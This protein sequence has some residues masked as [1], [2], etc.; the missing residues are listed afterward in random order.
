M[1]GDSAASSP[2]RLEAPSLTWSMDFDMDHFSARLQDWAP[3]LVHDM[4]KECLAIA[5]AFGITDVQVT[6]ILGSIALS[7][8]YP[9][10]IKPGQD[11]EFTYYALDQ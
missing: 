10:I 7:Q 11:P 9:A 1:S 5:T 3:D 4:T 8:S 6:C 2:F